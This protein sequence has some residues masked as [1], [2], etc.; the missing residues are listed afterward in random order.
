M[1]LNSLMKQYLL[2]TTPKSG[3]PM[4][5]KLV[6]AATLEQ[7]ITLFVARMRADGLDHIGP[8]DVECL[9]PDGELAEN[10]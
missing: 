4:R 8:D 6:D 2:S 10:G 7:A 3:K 1:S 5:R 9:D